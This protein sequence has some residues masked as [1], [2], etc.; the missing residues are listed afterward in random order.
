M[1]CVCVL[2]VPY[3]DW[4]GLPSPCLCKNLPF[5]SDGNV[6]RSNLN[7]DSAMTGPSLSLSALPGLPLLFR[8]SCRGFMPVILSTPSLHYLNIHDGIRDYVKN[9]M[10]SAM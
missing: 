6:G 5:L 2:F 10:H 4:Y 9:R 1:M 7:S 3:L 8:L